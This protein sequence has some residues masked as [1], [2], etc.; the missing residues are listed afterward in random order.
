MLRSFYE[1]FGFI[2]SILV[3][4]AGFLFMIFWVSGIAGISQL[5][6]SKTKNFKLVLSALL[7]PYAFIWLMIDM[8]K[9]HDY[10]T[11]DQK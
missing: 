3:S 5:P 4:L 1:S 11:D 10:M 2:G 7:P 8:Y 6:E 9:Q